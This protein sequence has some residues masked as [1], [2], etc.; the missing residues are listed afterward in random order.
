MTVRRLGY[1]TLNAALHAA[2]LSTIIFSATG[3]IFCQTR[4]ANLVVLIAIAFSW[5]GLGAI[6]GKGNGYG[7]C[8]ITDLQWQLKRR[9]GHEPPTWGYMKVLVDGLAARDVD[10]VLIE[11]TTAVAFFFCLAAS[12][13][14]TL[15]SGGC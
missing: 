10:E 6:L 7:Y 3:W 8:L 13:A 11:R 9:M 2:H 12:A 15:L 4:I 1:E 5:Y 14:L